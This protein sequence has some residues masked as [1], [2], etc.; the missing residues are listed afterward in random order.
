VK[1]STDFVGQAPRYYASDCNDRTGNWQT[2]GIWPGYTHILM[3]VYGR[4][5]KEKTRSCRG[6]FKVTIM[7]HEWCSRDT[8]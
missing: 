8:K 7:L 2:L 6:R 3:K 4:I 1:G 5:N